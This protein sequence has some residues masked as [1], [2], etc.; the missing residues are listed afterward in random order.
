[1]VLQVANISCKCQYHRTTFV[2]NA[3]IIELVLLLLFDD[4]CAFR[5]LLDQ[6]STACLEKFETQKPPGQIWTP[7]ATASFP[8]RSPSRARLLRWGRDLT[9]DRT[10]GKR[11]RALVVTNDVSAA[12]RK[13]EHVFSA[14]RGCPLSLSCWVN[15]PILDGRLGRETKVK[16]QESVVTNRGKR[17]SSVTIFL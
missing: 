2:A 3:S 4:L 17:V 1:M 6:R 11:P 8:C 12:P 7:L 10:L 5:W 14:A 16:S 13:S 9:R 15:R